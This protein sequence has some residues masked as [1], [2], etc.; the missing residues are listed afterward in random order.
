MKVAQRG[1]KG[2]RT[3]TQSRLSVG[4]GMKFSLLLILALPQLKLLPLQQQLLMPTLPSE[5]V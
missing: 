1:A 5:L 3:F 2:L 4:L